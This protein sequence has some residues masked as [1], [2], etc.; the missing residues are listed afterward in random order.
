MFKKT[1][2]LKRRI[3]IWSS[4]LILI[5]EVLIIGFS[6]KVAS[7][8]AKETGISDAKA[9]AIQEKLVIENHFKQAYDIA[10]TISSTVMTIRSD[11]AIKNKR[12]VV[13]KIIEDIL[14]EN[15]YFIGIGIGF[16]PNVFDNEDDKYGRFIPY[17]TYQNRVLNNVPIKDIETSEFYRIPKE[18]LKPSIMEPYEYIVQGKSVLMTTIVVPIIEDNKFIG[19]VGVDIPIDAVQ[20]KTM[21]IVANQTKDASIVV[22]SNKGKIVAC[23]DRPKL[24]KKH[25]CVLHND[26]IEDIAEVE[27]YEIASEF[28]EKNK[29]E[30]ILSINIGDINTPWYIF[31]EIEEAIMLEDTVSNTYIITIIGLI[32]MVLSMLILRFL[33]NKTVEP[34]LLLTNK[35]DEFDINNIDSFELDSSTLSEVNTLGKVYSHILDKLKENFIFRDKKD[36]LQMGQVKINNLIQDS[37]QIQELA[38]QIVVFVTKQVNGQIGMLYL[39]DTSET[40]NEEK[41][42]NLIASY[43][44]KQ[45]K[46]IATSYKTGEGIIGQVAQEREMITISDIPSDYVEIDLGVGSSIPKNIVVVPCEINNEVIAVLEIGLISEM[47]EDAIEYL[48]LIKT[49]IAIA[50]SNIINFNNVENLLKQTKLQSSELQEQQEKLKNSNEELYNQHEELRVMNEE[51][52]QNSI[53][54]E[55]KARDIE[56]ANQY[57]SE[58]LANMSHELRTPLN[59]ILIL[60]EL[61][62]ENKEKHLDDKEIEFA[63]TINSSGRDLNLRF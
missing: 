41:Q 36:W 37:N 46:G 56:M 16:E 2:S 34:I 38:N 24:L 54:L 1:Q 13:E 47:T 14:V 62:S 12:K 52:K 21:E 60:S 43:A 39:L 53:E 25:I 4:L 6:Y 63:S 20:N 19:I 51:L 28:N 42:F 11:D 17:I 45:R 27:K 9:T 44:Y 8:L 22:V 29:F 15:P 57:K 59:S 48:E 55:K 33:V 61:L 31:Y 3:M 50:F 10:G 40:E 35:M 23:N 49:N 26:Y 5:T 18:T 32:T 7:D 30:V 58:F